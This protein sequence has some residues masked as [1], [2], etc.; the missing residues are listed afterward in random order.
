MTA[1]NPLPEYVYKIGTD[2]PS[3][4]SPNE[5]LPLSDLDRVSPTSPSTPELLPLCPLLFILSNQRLNPTP[6]TQK[7]GF[8]HLST[9]SQVPSTVGRFFS[10][11]P[12]ITLL[13]IRLE[14]IAHKMR[15]D[16][17]RGHGVFPHV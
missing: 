11:S 17:S 13:K 8:I 16:E 1:P 7:D 12:Q 15:W 3:E 4:T 5:A 10:S 14:S 9:A 6:P 2:F